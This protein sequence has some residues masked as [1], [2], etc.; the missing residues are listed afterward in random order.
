MTTS[1][2][3]ISTQFDTVSTGRASAIPLFV[4]SQQTY[5]WS[6]AW[7]RDEQEALQLIEEGSARRFSSGAA[8]SAWLLSDED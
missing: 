3:D 4:P 8:A 7:Q 5:Y 2:I 1:T 6:A